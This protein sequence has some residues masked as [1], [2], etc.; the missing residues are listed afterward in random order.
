MGF[1]GLRRTDISALAIGHQCLKI[2]IGRN[3]TC[4][5]QGGFMKLAAFFIDQVVSGKNQI[6]AGLAFSGVGVDIGANQTGGLALHQQTSA[7]G[8]AGQIRNKRTGLR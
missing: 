6:G 8:P 2:D 4:G 5:K 3:E 1:C 7:G